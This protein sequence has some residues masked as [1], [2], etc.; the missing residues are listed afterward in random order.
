MSR[1]HL[2]IKSVSLG[3]RSAPRGFLLTATTVTLL[4]GTGAATIIISRAKGRAHPV[5][6]S[7]SSVNLPPRRA[8]LGRARRATRWP[9]LRID[10][11]DEGPVEVIPREQLATLPPPITLIMQPLLVSDVLCIGHERSRHPEATVLVMINPEYF[12]PRRLPLSFVC[13]EWR[14]KV[15]EGLEAES[16]VSAVHTSKHFPP[17]SPVN[18]SVQHGLPDVYEYT[19]TDT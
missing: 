18:M 2:I 16:I 4:V 3:T 5:D 7:H 11:V 14:N 9:D 19:D 6:E 8:C 15:V 10:V 13:H 1:Q 12:I 17:Q